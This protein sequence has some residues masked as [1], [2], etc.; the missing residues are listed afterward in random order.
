MGGDLLSKHE[1]KLKNYE[2]INGLNFYFIEGIVG[3]KKLYVLQKE[4][5]LIIKQ[6]LK[7]LIITLLSI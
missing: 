3:S 1:F 4:N 5:T 7:N 6:K 2:V